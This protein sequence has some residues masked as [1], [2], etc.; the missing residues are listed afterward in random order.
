MPT[1]ETGRQRDV[2]KETLPT[3]NDG[4][5]CLFIKNN[6]INWKVFQSFS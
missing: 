5:W 4:E 3:D 6:N 1:E 2:E